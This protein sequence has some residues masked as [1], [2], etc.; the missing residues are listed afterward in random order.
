MLKE[1][2]NPSV[3]ETLVKTI[4]FEAGPDWAACVQVGAVCYVADAQGM[5]QLGEW[6]HDPLILFEQE[7]LFLA[8]QSGNA[9]H[10]MS[11]Q[12]MQS[13]LNR[14]GAAPVEHFP[15]FTFTPQPPPG[16]GAY[17]SHQVTLI[18]EWQG[19]KIGG[20]FVGWVPMTR[21]WQ[22][23]IVVA[24]GERVTGTSVLGDVEACRR[25]KLAWRK[26]EAANK[27]QET[28]V[29]SDVESPQ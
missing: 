13:K 3:G 29:P 6:G 8:D 5:A 20:G 10:V 2:R 23:E 15:F 11:P 24:P 1:V 9:G 4:T 22:S 18:E 16:Q 25:A 28:E 19:W 26:W 21:T 17:A 7:R 14:A 12:A 27:P